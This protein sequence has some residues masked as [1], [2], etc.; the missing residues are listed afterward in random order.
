MLSDRAQVFLQAA[1]RVFN[2]E[3]YQEFLARSY[4]IVTNRAVQDD[5]S[6]TN[7]HACLSHFML[8]RKLAL[9]I[10]IYSNFLLL[11]KCENA[12]TNTYPK[13]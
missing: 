5:L 2:D 6:K 4:R 7:I 13:K 1:L 3:S 11:R 9:F 10:Y 12:S 8:V